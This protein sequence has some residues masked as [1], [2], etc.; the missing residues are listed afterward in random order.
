MSASTYVGRIGALAAAFGVGAAIFT[1]PA[2][3]WA[4]PA[5]PD[6]AGP[7]ATDA[8]A[9]AQA[10]AEAAAPTRGRAAHSAR[11]PRTADS[12]AST[13]TPK[14]T[15]S[16][17]DTSA[18]D[19]A[20]VV[21]R[22]L[23]P[24]RASDSAESAPQQSADASPGPAAA[25][26]AKANND[27]PAVAPVAAASELSTP[28]EVPSPAASLATPAPAAAQTV[29]SLIEAVTTAVA[30]APS[31][32]AKTVTPV[33][34]LPAAL[35]NVA[36]HISTVI[37]SVVTQ[38]VN[39]FSGS[40][41]F[42][43]QVDSPANWLLLAVARRQ[44]IGAA[45][46]AAAT[47]ASPTPALILNGYSVVPSSTEIIDSFTGRWAYWP[48]Q[49]NM[50]QGRQDFNLVN[51]T[52][53]ETVGSFSA[54][55]TAGDPTSI[56]AHY[57]RMLITANDGENVGTGPG[58]TPP[59]GSFIAD[60]TL[61][62]VGMSYSSMPTPS[63]DKV[64]VKLRTPFGSFPL[65][66]T[67]NASAGIADH[68]FDNRPMDVTG[69]FHIAPTNPL[70][71]KITATIGTLPLFN[72]VQGKQVFGVF[73]STGKKVGTFDGEFTT[74]SDTIG[75]STQAILVTANSGDNVGTN[76][77]QTPPVG[78]VYNVAYFGS[79]KVWLLYSSM[80]TKS[81]DVVTIKL[82]TPGGVVDL[83]NILFNNFN[84]STEP[85]MKSM[86]APGGQKF[87]ATSAVI[88]AGVNGLPPRDVQIQGYQQFDVVNFLGQKIG[89][90]D[91]DVESQWD[92]FGIHSK[93]I[94]ITKV[95]SGSEGATPLNVPPVGTVMNF[96]DM[97]NG[98]GFADSVIPQKGVDVAAFQFVTPLGN[99]PLLPSI[100]VA[101]HPTV[102]YFNPFLV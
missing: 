59:V 51:P 91:A 74:T 26:A 90:I 94:L 57:V 82:G 8:P 92:G 47:S 65:P 48:G 64:S 11:T 15:R 40:S 10:P 84:A 36:S 96:I 21:Q 79:D 46:T 89:S 54:L 13:S 97:G 43:P 6:T 77:G 85:T 73:D 35:T 62:I 68:T 2:I 99:I 17:S 31:V 83:P 66:F 69:G 39:T 19:L 4:D 41:P 52:T 101:N 42:G 88:P 55:V 44:P 80:P 102:D 61:G 75:I 22:D 30:P 3:A 18:P 49:P 67:Y 24:R 1:G 29:T 60:F 71:E 81:G 12:S 63:G 100:V 70:A 72:S 5:S 32:S 98:F 95:T 37:N 86:I 34:T 93:S 28:A 87:V 25:T 9:G 33:V 20:D 23:T 58:Q 56:G 14:A 78:T 16:S 50:L 27:V 38:L 53:E 45:A 7:S 76:P